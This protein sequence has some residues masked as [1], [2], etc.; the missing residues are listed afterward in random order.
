MKLDWTADDILAGTKPSPV[1]TR[2]TYRVEDSGMT[3]TIY[4][5]PNGRFSYYLHWGSE[6]LASGVRQG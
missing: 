6:V 5:W 1:P 2:K 4:H 3:V